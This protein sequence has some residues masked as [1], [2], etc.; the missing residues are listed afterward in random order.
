[1]NRT[2][3]ANK[4]ILFARILDLYEESSREFEQNKEY[5]FISSLCTRPYKH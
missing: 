3:G 4:S 2:H 5:L 1:M